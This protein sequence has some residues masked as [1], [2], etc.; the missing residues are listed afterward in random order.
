MFVNA[1]QWQLTQKWNK[2]FVIIERVLL[3]LQLFTGFGRYYEYS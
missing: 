1:W 3:R 2:S